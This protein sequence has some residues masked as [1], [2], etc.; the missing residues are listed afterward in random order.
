[1][2]RLAALALLFA[3]PA[4]ADEKPLSDI[5]RELLLEKLKEIQETSNSTVKGRF[6]VA[7][8]AFKKARE[9]DAAAHDLYL[10]CIEKVRFEDEARKTSEFRDWKK[11]HKDRTDSAGF[12]L[13]LRHQLN[14]L[15]LS[16]EA[17]QL[18]DLTSLSGQ[19]IS[20]LE[21]ILRDAEKLKGQERL[22]SSPALSS[23]FA[24]AY[25]VNNAKPSGWP[26]APLKIDE[27]Y[28]MIVLPPLRTP[29]SLDALRKGWL[30]RIEHEG[31]LLEKWTDGGNA[32]KD[33]KP[34]FDKWLVEGR[35]D[36]LW[37]MEVDLFQSGDQRG[38]AIR[39]LEHLKKDLTHKSAPRWISQFTRLVEGG[40]AELEEEETE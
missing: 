38:A 10:N 5:D 18:E 31:L 9:S 20:V 35:K 8:A 4:L 21:A 3:S 27:I 25:G 26:D 33:R 11:R 17:A 19:S 6:G 16:L 14:W 40:P 13:A 34:A 7:L 39:M 24:D 1:M 15:V 30:K 2:K 36:L 29:D 12:R 32:D 37:A 23:I 28:E 22:L